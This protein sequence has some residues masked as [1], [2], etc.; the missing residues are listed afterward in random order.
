MKKKDNPIN[1][2]KKKVFWVMLVFLFLVLLVASFFGKKGWLE[3]HNIQKKKE[4]LK[5]EIAQLEKKK[6]QLLREIEE[7]ENNPSAVESKAREKLWLMKPGEK[8]IV[9]KKKTKK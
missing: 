2:W 5:E 1:A 3:I 9:E 7:L 8:V 4:N 6:V